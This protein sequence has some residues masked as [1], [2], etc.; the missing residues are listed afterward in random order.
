VSF[1]H[2]CGKELKTSA[3]FCSHCGIK[4][5]GLHEPES[6]QHAP[7]PRRVPVF[8]VIFILALIY[9]VLNAW[10]MGQVQIDTSV[11]SVL[12]SI[13]SAKMN[14]GLTQSSVQ[15][16]I[17]LKNPTII[18]VLITQLSYDASYGDTI[19]SD[20]NTGFIFIGP[21]ATTDTDININ[22]YPINAGVALVQGVA[23]LIQGQK[24]SLTIQFYAGL[25][26]IKIP[27]GAFQ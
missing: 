20:G 10:A 27:I 5:K 13:G 26:P 22:V 17:R 4:H 15:S 14:V 1:C 21:F 7:K 23:N 9:L 12:N 6:E 24:K 16:S 11:S 2:N 3:S 25:G 19:V 8:L 18:P